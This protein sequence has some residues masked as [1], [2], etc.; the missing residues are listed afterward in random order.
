MGKYKRGRN[1]KEFE[2]ALKDIRNVLSQWQS[3]EDSLSARIKIDTILKS[4][5]F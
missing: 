5:G 4:R 1:M 3:L 2:E